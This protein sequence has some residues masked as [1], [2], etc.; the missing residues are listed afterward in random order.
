[1]ETQWGDGKPGTLVVAELDNEMGAIGNWNPRGRFS[2]SDA[3]YVPVARSV[4]AWRSLI[5][6]GTR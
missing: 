2:T 6:F 3:P 4:K 5:N 1:M